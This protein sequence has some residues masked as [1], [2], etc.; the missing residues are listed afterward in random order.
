MNTPLVQVYILSRNR[1]EFLKQALKSCLEIDYPN[2]EVIVS[3]N[4]TNEDIANGLKNHPEK[5]R[6]K[7]IRR[8]EMGYFNQHMNLIKS[9]VSAPYFIIFHDD[10]QFL[11]N[12]LKTY[13]QIMEE[14]PSVGACAAN[15]KMIYRNQKS[16][17][18]YYQAIQDRIVNDDKE[19]LSSYYERSHGH[20]PFPFYM[21]RTNV[22]R[23]I[24]VNYGE[25]LIHSD[26]AFLYKIMKKSALYWSTVVVGYYHLHDT[27]I[28]R[29]INLRALNSLYHFFKNRTGD[30]N[31]V[32]YR[33]K[34]RNRLRYYLQ[35]RSQLFQWLKN[36]KQRK[37]FC[38]T[39]LFLFKNLDFYIHKLIKRRTP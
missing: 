29:F 1:L 38:E 5:N 30:P 32:V 33:Y 39:C 21:Y 14:N 6:F 19:F 20:P 25:G 4:S 24:A 2:F 37:L 31:D 8:P 34:L 23:D 11:P 10:D 16:E 15:T 12:V 22:V 28:S 9:E 17:K 26:G 3:D 27:N 7:L 18:L 35:N 36:S 13:I